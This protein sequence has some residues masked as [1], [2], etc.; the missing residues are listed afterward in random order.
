MERHHN[1]FERVTK[2]TNHIGKADKFF[3]SWLGIHN[4]LHLRC[5]IGRRTQSWAMQ[6]LWRTVCNHS[7]F[8]IFIAE[9]CTRLKRHWQRNSSVCLRA[10]TFPLYLPN[11]NQ[12]VEVM[13]LSRS[14]MTK[15]TQNSFAANR[16]DH[17]SYFI[18][19]L[20]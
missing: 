14:H 10:T 13:R 20:G 11:Y 4:R 3:N 19:E 12:F 2:K 9:G 7:L 18:L 1:H 16:G 17:N 6:L 5:Q 8:V 15:V